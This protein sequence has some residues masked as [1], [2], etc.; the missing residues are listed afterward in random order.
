MKNYKE[1]ILNGQSEVINISAEKLW[2]I[3][4]PGFADAGIW[5]TAVDQSEG[6]GTGGFE[7]AEFG[8]R[9]CELNTS[10]FDHVSEKLTQYNVAKMELAYKVQ[11]GMPSFVTFAENHWT[12]IKVG[13]NQSVVKLKLTMHMTKIMGGLMGGMM[14]MKLK[15]LFQLVFNDLKVYAE[16]GH[17]SKEKAKRMAKLSNKQVA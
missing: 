14:K 12:I 7:G 3:V 10:G 5:S 9:V 13:E 17:V 1:M 15:N 4:G 8:E 11:T 16:T 2:E 6:A